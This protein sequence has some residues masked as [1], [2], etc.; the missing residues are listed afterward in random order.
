MYDDPRFISSK[1]NNPRRSQKGPLK[2]R[3]SILVFIGVSEKINQTSKNQ[4]SSTDTFNLICAVTQQYCIKQS[5]NKRQFNMGYALS[6][7]NV[8]RRCI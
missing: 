5:I 4:L 1:G 2:N 7:T 8:C 3:G 6:G